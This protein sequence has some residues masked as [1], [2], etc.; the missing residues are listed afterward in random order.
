M[1]RLL[2]LCTLLAGSQLALAQAPAA[3]AKPKY[4]MPPVCTAACHEPEANQLGGYF[5]SAAFKSQGLQ[6]DVGSALPQILRFDP[7]T[8]KVIDA[9]KPQPTDHLRD[10]RKRSIG[11][12]SFTPSAAFHDGSGKYGSP[13]S[14]PKA[15]TA[16][17][18]A[19]M[20]RASSR[21]TDGRGNGRFSS[22]PNASP[23]PAP[24]GRTWR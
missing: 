22:D 4:I 1:L 11:L 24:S 3:P 13:C 9:G 23:S 21:V 8:L 5:E 7:K 10:V 2:T 17:S 19:S 18:C 20:A 15:R 14:R 12:P 6:I 16:S